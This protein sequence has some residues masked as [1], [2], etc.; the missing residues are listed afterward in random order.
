LQ[1]FTL[2]EL[3]G[4]TIITSTADDERVAFLKDAWR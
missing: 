3:G 2:E 4:K 1:D